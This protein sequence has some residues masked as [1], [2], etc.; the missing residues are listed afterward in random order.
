LVEVAEVAVL[1]PLVQLTR[2]PV[3]EASQMEEEKLEVAELLTAV[4]AAVDLA[5]AT[6]PTV[7]VAVAGAPEW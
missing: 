6:S 5:R 1:T 3:V 7:R 4:E 2:V